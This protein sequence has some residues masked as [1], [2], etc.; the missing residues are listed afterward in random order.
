MEYKSYEG[1]SLELNPKSPF[2]LDHVTRYWWA[3]SRCKDKRVLDC[4][5]G[6]GYG[7]Y[8]LSQN[9]KQVTGVDLNDNS[10]A[11]AS[12][13]FASAEN[14]SY[15]KYNVMEL[16][17]KAEK[18]DTIT[19]FEVIEHLDPEETDL[20]LDSLASAL[21][22]DGELLLS[23][24]NH[25]VVLKSRSDVPSFHIN[26]FRATEL[27]KALERHFEDVTMVGQFR[28]RGSVYNTLFSLDILNLRHTLKNLFKAPSRIVEVSDDED[29]DKTEYM[30]SN[31][32]DITHFQAPPEELS[33][34]E[35]SPRH[36]RQAGLSVCICKKPRK[37][38]A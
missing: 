7:S 23:T 36:W 3:S 26:N 21:S 24:P 18:F 9:A 31:P 1:D 16:D 14:L 13:V 8:I 10:L 20:F 29:M 4:A 34:Y 2:F 22:V 32:L 17:K 28:R 5:S 30:Q 19:A 25:D 27:K 38:R 11:L 37:H 33:E 35:F 12:K 6:K 15:E